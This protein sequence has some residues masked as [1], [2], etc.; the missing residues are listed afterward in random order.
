MT[1][2]YELRNSKQVVQFLQDHI[3]LWPLLTEARHYIRN[4]FGSLPPTLEVIA[5]PDGGASIQLVDL[6]FNLP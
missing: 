1:A 6:Y 5:D 2:G 4:V 3:Y